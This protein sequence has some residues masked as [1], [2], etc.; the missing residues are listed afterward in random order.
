MPIG[1][2]PGTVCRQAQT[3]AAAFGPEAEVQ[4]LCSQLDVTIV[5]VG[6]S[7]PE[8]V[9]ACPCRDIRM[10]GS[11]VLTVTGRMIADDVDYRRAGATG[12][13]Q[14]W[15]SIGV[16]GAQMKQCAGGRGCLA[17]IAVGGADATP[18]NRQC[19]DRIPASL[20]GAETNCILLAPAL[21]KQVGMPLSARV[22]MS[23]SAPFS[24]S[25]R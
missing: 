13:V 22:C 8:R 25:L 2:V 4:G 20:S 17:S 1:L 16:S 11:I 6:G 12:F 9:G 21:A 19:T 24:R 10:Q 14:V 15:A 23:A 18:S 7:G 5:C 3:S